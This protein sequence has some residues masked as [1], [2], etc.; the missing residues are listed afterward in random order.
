MDTRVL[1][2]FLTVAHTNNITR[3]AKQ[4][5]ITQPTLSRQIMELE[6]ELDTTLFDR[7][8]RH[9]QL[10]EAGVLFQQRATTLLQLIDQTKD[11]LHQ[12][13]NKLA[14]TVNLG[15]A[16]STASPFLMRL[17]DEFQQQYPG[18][19]FSIFDGDGDV[20]RRQIDEGTADLACLLEPV[21][22]AKYNYLVLPIKEQWGVIMLKDDP[23]ANRQSISKNDLYKLPLIL[24]HRNIIRDEVSDVLKLDQTKLNIKANNN[25][26][27]NTLELIRKG[28]YYA[29]SIKGVVDVLNDPSICFVPFSPK[30]E[31]GHVVVWRRNNVLAPAAEKFLQ[32]IAEKSNKQQKISRN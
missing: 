18:V 22:A 17:V 9:L 5:H 4:L 30:K 12:Q 23:L 11:D 3:A 19:Q 28:H 26:P 21:E 8:Q 14:G 16:V 10:T 25:L 32:F 6:R 7:E 1:K 24:P 31:T 2:Y 29:V 20:L 13:E 15:C 27:S